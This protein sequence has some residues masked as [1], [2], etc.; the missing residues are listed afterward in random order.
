MS[1]RRTVAMV[2]YAPLGIRHPALSLTTIARMLVP[3]GLL[4][5]LQFE[6]NWSLLH[7]TQA[8]IDCKSP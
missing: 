3:A 4:R 8:S 5:T 1:R 2:S 6:T 7:T